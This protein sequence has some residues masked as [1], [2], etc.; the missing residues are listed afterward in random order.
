MSLS[1]DIPFDGRDLTF[2]EFSILLLGLL[3][4]LILIIL[5]NYK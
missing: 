1:G 4:F 5:V 2:K 3:L